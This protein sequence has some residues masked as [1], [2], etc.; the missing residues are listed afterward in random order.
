MSNMKR[1][2]PS[3]P[4]AGRKRK[5][6]LRHSIT[7]TLRRKLA[8]EGLRAGTK[9]PSL[10]ELAKDLN[11]STMTVLRAIRTLESEGYLC[12]IPAVG[13]FISQTPAP[14]QEVPT[15][16]TVAFAAVD[17]KSA[18][19][20]EIA[21]G[22]EK[23][24]QQY[25]W[26]VRI[27]D[28][29]DDAGHCARNLRR[30]QQSGAGGA[31]ILPLCDPES[32]D[33]LVRLK[34]AN[35]SFVLVDR[36]APGIKADL[37]ESNH[38][39]GAYLAAKYCIELGHTQLLMLTPVPAA[40]S[41]V[42]DRI[43]GF[44]RALSDAHI[45]ANQDNIV[46]VDDKLALTGRLEEQRWL[47]GYKAILPVL[48][49]IQ[50]PVAVVAVEDRTG[51]GVYQACREAGLRIPEDVSVI[52]FDNTEIARGMTPPMAA[53]A[54]RTAD[55]GRLAVDLLRKRIQSARGQRQSP[56]V[57]THMVVDVDL[58]EAQSVSRVSSIQALTP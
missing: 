40:V 57:Y 19:D 13:I 8:E 18:F 24:C 41:S 20:I 44:Q 9:L 34:S 36:A 12:R 26:E 5:S 25:G 56:E 17:L 32:N 6:E 28:G 30:L 27:F 3:G 50:P 22:I 37:V 4:A 15:E 38:E 21:H 52:C 47:G 23:A 46:W 33:T 10:R 58:V 39:G 51:W 2:E 45:Q 11:V 16:C 31:I 54:Q 43:R 42:A 49:N 14:S 29:Q 1:R 35:F 48:Q 55:I 7:E 53:V